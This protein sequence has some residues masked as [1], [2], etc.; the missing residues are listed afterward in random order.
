[1][2]FIN[3]YKKRIHYKLIHSGE[4]GAEIPV[5]VFLHEGLGSIGQWRSFPEKLCKATGFQGLVYERIGYGKSDYWDNEIPF[6][7]LH[8]EAFEMLPE[9]LKQLNIHQDY[10]VF[11]H[12]DGGTMA[13]LHASLNPENLKGIVVEAPHVIIEKESIRGL[14]LT[15]LYLKNEE[16]IEKLGK[17]HPHGSRRLLDEW[18][19]FWLSHEA[20]EW[21][22]LD[23]LMR[24]KV[25]SLLIQ[26]DKDHFGT[27]EQLYTIKKLSQGKTEILELCDCGHVPHLEKEKEVL[28]AAISFFKTSNTSPRH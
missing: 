21:Q 11:G 24:I 4:W 3:I 20:Q 9:L 14:K 18:T 13:L 2:S 12:S 15:R 28:E 25:P 26:G 1:M 16:W 23:D 10:F 17:H 22:M 7:F 19:A 27:F 8:Y 6:D 5:I